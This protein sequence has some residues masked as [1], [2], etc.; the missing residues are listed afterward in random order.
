MLSINNELSK[1]NI[2]VTTTSHKECINSNMTKF[3]I[4]CN[5]H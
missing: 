1:S 3:K 4:N 5:S 2:K